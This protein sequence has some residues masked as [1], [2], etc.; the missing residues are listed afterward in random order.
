MIKSERNRSLMKT[1]EATKKIFS[2]RQ[3]SEHEDS[4]TIPAKSNDK[5]QGKEEKKN[6]S[7]RRRRRRRNKTKIIHS[8][9]PRAK[10]IHSK[11]KNRKKTL[12]S[13]KRLAAKV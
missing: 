6:R 10:L 2:K 9:E 8:K 13:T 12:K 4:D 3:D 11:R 7:R 5:Q 1:A